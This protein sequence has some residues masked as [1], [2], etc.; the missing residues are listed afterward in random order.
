MPEQ[1][2][3]DVA[4]GQVRRRDEEVLGV[5]HPEQFRVQRL[6]DPRRRDDP[7]RLGEGRD[8]IGEAPGGVAGEQ[9]RRRVEDHLAAASSLRVGEVGP[10]RPPPEAVAGE[11]DHHEDHRGIGVEPV[12]SVPLLRPEAEVLA[13]VLGQP[14]DGPD[15]S[16]H[17]PGPDLAGLHVAHLD[18]AVDPGVRGPGLVTAQPAP[19]MRPV[20]S[21]ASC[22]PAI[23]C[24]EIVF[25]E[26]AAPPRW[27]AGVTGRPRC[28]AE[29]WPGSRPASHV[30]QPDASAP[31]AWPASSAP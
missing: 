25:F 29:A 12:V 17:E 21:A 13:G 28:I 20:T 10:D 23:R 31:T 11:A 9:V 14:L 18:E 6:L 16:G 22:W 8:Q 15:L 7:A 5:D 1:G 2:L 26:P 19:G 30:P 3:A 24:G 27:K 4:A